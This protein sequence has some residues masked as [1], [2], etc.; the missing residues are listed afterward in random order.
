MSLE[1]EIIAKIV[2]HLENPNDSLIRSQVE[3]FRSKSPSNEAFFKDFERIWHLAEDAEPL[4]AI[5]KNKSV[6]KLRNRISKK[7]VIIFQKKHNYIRWSV[8]SLFLFVIATCTYLYSKQEKIF[9][10]LNRAYQS[11]ALPGS[12]KAVLTLA[13]GKQISLNDLGNRKVLK[14]EGVSISKTAEGMLIYTVSQAPSG[15]NWKLA[16]NTIETPKGGMWKVKLLDGSLVW[17]NSSSSLTYPVSFANDSKRQ[18]LLKGE[19]YF[20]IVEDHLHPFVVKTN[21]QTILVTGT[22]F[23]VNSYDDENQVATTLM[24]G[25]ISVQPN[26]NSRQ[27]ILMKPGEQSIISESG[28]VVHKVDAEAS[29]AWKNGYFMFDNEKQESIMRKISRWYNVQVTYADEEAKKVS[30]YG[31]VSRFENVSK[32]LRKFEKT[33]EVWFEIEGNHI[34]VH[35]DSKN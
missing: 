14:E 20:E 35:K 18:V 15:V 9:P 12:N 32:V 2:R 29:I 17:L 33:G 24:E 28:V 7:S 31:S 27:Q 6:A 19:A 23:N 16:F 30:Y 3:D 34:I 10:V 25:S 11:D 5:D 1:S 22:H 26:Q 13:D 8:A 21:K 4:E